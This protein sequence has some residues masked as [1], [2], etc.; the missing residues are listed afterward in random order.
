MEKEKKN[1]DSS[2]PS[3]SCVVRMLFP[4]CRMEYHMADLDFIGFG[5]LFSL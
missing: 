3:F 5:G 4:H 1:E 2:F